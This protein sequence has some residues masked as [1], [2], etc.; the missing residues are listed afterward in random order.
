MT[1]NN[2]FSTDRVK[3]GVNYPS[4]D[5]DILPRPILKSKIKNLYPICD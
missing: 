3:I 1:K 5:N 4:W 2:L